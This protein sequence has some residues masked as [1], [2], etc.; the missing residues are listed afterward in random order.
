MI[1]EGVAS[2]W[3]LYFQVGDFD[4]SAGHVQWQRHGGGLMAEPEDIEGVRTNGGCPGFRKVPASV[5]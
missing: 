2:G 1:E 5:S 3:Y 4:E